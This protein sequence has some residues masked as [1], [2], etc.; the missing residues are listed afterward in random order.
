MKNINEMSLI[1]VAE[2]IVFEKKE[3]INIYDL[4][5]LVATE[6]G[7]SNPEKAAY[8]SQFYSDLTTSAKF[9]YVGENKWDLKENQKIELWEKDGSFY[10][11]YTEVDFVDD[12]AP[13]KKPKKLRKTK[14]K[15]KAKAKPKAKPVVE[16]VVEVVAEVVAEPV[17]EPVVEKVV[18][19]VVEAVPEKTADPVVDVV[20]TE[21]EVPEEEV[22]EDFD[23]DK[24]NEYMDT[25]EDR[26]DE[27]K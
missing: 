15:A 23:E 1:V 27:K 11:E 3:A 21:T 9:S 6:K 5:D 4:F 19:P 7:L 8:I 24:Y 20:E 18:E 17:V 2:R 25:Y 12:E 16:E 22:F 13:V 14:A 10:N 26:Y